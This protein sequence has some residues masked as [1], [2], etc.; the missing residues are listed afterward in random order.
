MITDWSDAYRNSRYIEGGDSYPAQWTVAAA[1]FRARS[2]SRLDLRY[3]PGQRHLLDLF[4]PEAEPTGL[5]VFVHGGYWMAFDKSSWSHLAQGAV[6]RNWAVVVPSYTL[7]PQARI[8]G[9][10]VEVAQ[11][12]AHAA[13]LIDGPIRLAGHSAGGHLVSRMICDGAPL[14][15]RV[16]ARIAHVLTISGVH[17]LRPLLLTDLNRILMIDEA[18]ALAESPALLHPVPGARL[19]CWVGGGERPEFLRQNDL[20]ANIWTGL[21]AETSSHHDPGRH[22]FNVIEG[23][24]DPASPITAAFAG[25]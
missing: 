13:S 2:K 3:G 24:Q 8:A 10:T 21:G 9:I 18:E 7:A 4:L 23:L 5:A 19:A 1:E 17:D 11:A 6:A 22:H 25:P 15:P 12:I 16:R 14:P 20:L